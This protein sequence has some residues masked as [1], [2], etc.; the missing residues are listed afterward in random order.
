M[1]LLRIFAAALL[2]LVGLKRLRYPALF[3]MESDFR[4]GARASGV[5]KAIGAPPEYTWSGS[6]EAEHWLKG[7]CT[8]EVRQVVSKVWTY[9]RPP[10][11]TVVLGID[12]RGIVRCIDYSSAIILFHV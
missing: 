9:E 5:A 6:E 8:P 4:V 11:R 2:L 12:V 1:T 7:A 3:T 10:R